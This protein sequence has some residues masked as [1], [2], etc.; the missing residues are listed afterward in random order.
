MEGPY[1]PICWG[2]Q[3]EDRAQE[4]RAIVTHTCLERPE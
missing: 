4:A 1:Q 3:V 2:R